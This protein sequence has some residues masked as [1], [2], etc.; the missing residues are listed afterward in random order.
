M[1]AGLLGLSKKSN[2][3]LIPVHRVLENKLMVQHP[4]SGCIMDVDLAQDCSDFPP[5]GGEVGQG[6]TNAAHCLQ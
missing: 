4:S 3:A 1:T 2:K 6:P 5:T